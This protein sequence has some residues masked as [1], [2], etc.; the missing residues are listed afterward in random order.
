MNI[1]DLIQETLAEILKNMGVAFGKFKVS[2]EKKTPFGSPVYR[3]D[4]DSEE[5]AT[6][7]G[8]HGE[9]IAALQHL[10]KT[11]VWKRANENIFVVLD[12]DSYRKRQ[13][14]SVLAL[15]MRKVET[16]RKSLEDQVLPPMSPY[17][18][19]VVHTAL[20]GPGFEDITTESV[21]EGDRRAVTIK[22]KA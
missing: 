15:A 4:I 10:L 8:Y 21:G 17:F 18:R 16:A 11:L 3:I 2:V 1:E 9:T 20:T 12:V 14:E 19:R 5:A 22:V 13:E 7:I 6:L